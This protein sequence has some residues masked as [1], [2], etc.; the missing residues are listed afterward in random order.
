MTFTVSAPGRICLFGEHQDY[1]GLPVIAAA[2]SKRFYFKGEPNSDRKFKIK[3]LDLNETVE[4][5]LDDLN[6]TKPRDYF[7]SAIRVLMQNGY[8]VKNGVNAEAWS[9]IPQRAGVSSSSAM[10]N[11]WISCV[12][13]ANG[14][15]IPDLKILG[16]M[17]FTAEVIEFNEPG[18]MMDQYSTAIGGTIY[19]E[20]QPQLLI[21]SLSTIP[22]TFIL[23]DSNQ[24]KD[25]I[26]ILQFAR[27]KRLDIA[28]EIQS[29]NPDFNW[30]L[31]EKNTPDYL[32]RE[33]RDLY[34]GTIR[35]RDIL[36]EA[37]QLLRSGDFDAVN[38]GKLL[39]EHHGILSQTLKVSTLLIDTMLEKCLEAG[40][41]GGK[42][43]G[44]GGGGCFIVYAPDNP[45]EII[46]LMAV[47]GLKSW[48]VAVDQGARVELDFM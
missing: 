37:I 48:K 31:A 4:F 29:Q 26:G 9:E 21:Q 33:A 40:A 47:N 15:E 18:G 38:F 6:Y 25:T 24:P 11:A 23:V 42:I 32:V 1:L 10:T 36:L 46:E 14:Y 12:L 44:S 27:N 17:S 19:L 43:V 8:T 41:L 16:R 5:S 45:E 34:S 28:L 22:G 3:L 35:N 39:T 13:T 7:K 30:Q 20:S 2:I